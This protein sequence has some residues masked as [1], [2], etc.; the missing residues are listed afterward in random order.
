M[1]DPNPSPITSYRSP[2]SYNQGM[3]GS[4][5]LGGSG[6]VEDSD[7]RYV[8]MTYPSSENASVEEVYG[9]YSDHPLT[10]PEEETLGGYRQLPPS[11]NMNQQGY[12][13]PAHSN[14][15]DHYGQGY[16]YPLSSPQQNGPSS[17]SPPPPHHR[18]G[19][20]TLLP[21]ISSTTMLNRLPAESTLL[22]SLND[23]RATHGVISTGDGEDSRDGVK[24]GSRSTGS[25]YDEPKGTYE[26]HSH[27][28][29]Q[30]HTYGYGEY[31][32]NGDAATGPYS[33]GRNR[34][35]RDSTLLTPLNLEHL[36][37]GS[38]KGV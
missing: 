33:L 27:P 10:Q 14:N 34:L 9:G 3:H 22:S 36:R 37:F 4:S 13:I 35:P 16:S 31:E 17:A 21:P 5:N 30:N 8:S 24:S 32:N 2:S 29:Q 7:R 6:W 38:G 26:L 28:Q 18:Y 20:G 19:T 11:A 15:Q 25:E 23:Y 1:T 12:P